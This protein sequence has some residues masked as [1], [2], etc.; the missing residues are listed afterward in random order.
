[1]RHILIKP[2]LS[3]YIPRYTSYTGFTGARGQLSHY[4]LL[5]IL[6]HLQNKIDWKISRHDEI[7]I[8]S[9][10]L[11]LYISR[12]GIWSWE[13][14]PRPAHTIC[15]VLLVLLTPPISPALHCAGRSVGRDNPLEGRA[16]PLYCLHQIPV[17]HQREEEDVRSRGIHV[18]QVTILIPTWTHSVSGQST[19]LCSYT[20][21]REGNAL[22]TD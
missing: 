2:A 8:L 21:S 3:L 16:S 14:L 5:V 12:A 1:M 6:C 9:T 11:S 18:G 22:L 17:S 13:P 7:T 10:E 19:F 20:P 4:R 15:H